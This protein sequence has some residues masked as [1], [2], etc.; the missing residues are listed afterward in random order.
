MSPS[1]PT[2]LL[3]SFVEVVDAGTMLKAS[4]RV[5]LTPSAVS[6]QIKRLEGTR[7]NGLSARNHAL[8]CSRSASLTLRASNLCPASASAINDAK[9]HE[10][11]ANKE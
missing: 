5:F 1:L 8:S 3:R 4:E 9:A 10:P 11:G 7:P 2:E 6:L